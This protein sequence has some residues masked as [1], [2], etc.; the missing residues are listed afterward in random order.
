MVVKSLRLM[1]EYL[2]NYA[3]LD[4][5]LLANGNAG[6]LNTSTLIRN[7][8]SGIKCVIKDCN[9]ETHLFTILLADLLS[10]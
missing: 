5:T 1:Q 4:A 7:V 2:C 10:R 6:I 9:K 8:D 3:N